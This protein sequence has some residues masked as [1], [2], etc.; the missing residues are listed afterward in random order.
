MSRSRLRRRWSIQFF[1]R[2]PWDYF[3]G[4]HWNGSFTLLRI[5][6]RR[7]LREPLPPPQPPNY[8]PETIALQDRV[9][10]LREQGLSWTKIG[11]EV[12]RASGT[13][14]SLYKQRAER[15]AREADSP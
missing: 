4:E 3:D 12:D 15:V 9:F 11:A 14:S 7:E 6:W 10:E 8:R 1:R 2:R 5:A 13:C